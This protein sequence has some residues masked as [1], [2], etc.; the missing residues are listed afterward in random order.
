[1]GQEAGVGRQAQPRASSALSIS[2]GTAPAAATRSQA[3]GR[4]IASICAWR[5]AG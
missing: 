2:A 1:V 5:G 3:A 4:A